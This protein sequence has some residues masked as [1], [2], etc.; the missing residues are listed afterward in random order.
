LTGLL[1]LKQ[2][3]NPT[4]LQSQV[5][6]VMEMREW[7]MVARWLDTA[8]LT[9]AAAASINVPTAGHGFYNLYA[10]PQGQWWY[11]HYY[12][13][14]GSLLAAETI[15]LAPYMILNGANGLGRIQLGAPYADVITA[16]ARDFAATAKGFFAPPGASLNFQVMD[17]LTAANISVTGELLATPMPA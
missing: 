16:R 11:V 1:Q 4:I 2:Q 12:T 5:A 3:G 13:L 14:R 15:S 9:G 10:V 6:P 17:S 8:G 7:Y